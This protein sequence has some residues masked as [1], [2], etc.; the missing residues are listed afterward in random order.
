MADI[1]HDT[2]AGDELFPT[3]LSGVPEARATATD[4]DT[5]RRCPAAAHRPSPQ[6]HRPHPLRM[7]A[8]DGSL[9]GP[10]LQVQQGT[11]ATVEVT[12]DAGLEQ[13]VHGHGLRLWASTARSSSA[14]QA[15]ITGPPV[16]RDV[17]LT[18]DDLLL[19]DGHISVFHR[20]GPTHTMMG[21][22]GTV[23]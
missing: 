11:T 13:T 16:N 9:P 22:F 5:R 8:Y 15:W 12:N 20:S 7:L 10:L 17:A 1:T 2:S 3:D 14:R 4:P 19:Q 23:C 6:E 18:L 21:H